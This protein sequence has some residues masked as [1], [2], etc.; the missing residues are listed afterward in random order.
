MFFILSDS[1]GLG[2]NIK[3]KQKQ[4]DTAFK[5]HE[6]SAKAMIYYSAPYRRNQPDRRWKKIKSFSFISFSEKLYHS[7]RN[8]ITS[9]PA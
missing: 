2:W 6:F 3:A 8:C 1:R 9:P 7:F 5:M 4:H